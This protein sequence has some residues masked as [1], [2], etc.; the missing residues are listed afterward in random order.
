MLERSQQAAAT[1][2]EAGMKKQHERLTKAASVPKP[3][4]AVPSDAGCAAQGVEFET[5]VHRMVALYFGVA[6][7]AV[8][9]A[10]FLQYSGAHTEL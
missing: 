2:K 8:A 5:S 10:I 6:L 9:A 1:K 7:L 3:P 4:P